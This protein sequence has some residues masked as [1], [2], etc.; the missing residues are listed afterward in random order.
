MIL[1]GIISLFARAYGQV[2]DDY[3]LSVAADASGFAL[4]GG[5]WSWGGQNNIFLVKTD[6]DGIGEWATICGGAGNDEA[7]AITPTSDGGY[8]VAG[9]TFTYGIGGDMIVLKVTGTGSLSWARVIGG[10]YDDEARGIAEL[11]DGGYVVTGRAFIWGNGYDLIFFKLNSDGSYGGWMRYFGGT[12][13]DYGNW[14][15]PTSDG[16]FVITGGTTS[17]GPVGGD[18]TPVLLLNSSGIR[19]WFSVIGGNSS[20]STIGN[21]VIQT[22]DGGFAVAGITSDFGAGGYD[23]IVFKLNSSGSLVWART[24][25]GP[26]NDYAYSIAEMDDGGLVIAGTTESY[27]LGSNEAMVVKMSSDGGFLWARTFGGFEAGADDYDY[28]KAITETP[29]GLVALAGSTSSFGLSSGLYAFLVTMGPDGEYPAC[30]SV[31]DPNI[32]NISPSTTSVSGYNNISLTISSPSVSYSAVEPNQEALCLPVDGTEGQVAP[33]P[34][35]CR[36][37]PGGLIFAAGENIGLSV[38]SADGRLVYSGQLQ[39]GENRIN[40]DRGVYLWTTKPA[41]AGSRARLPYRGNAV[42]R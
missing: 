8:A 31:C 30:V 42:V 26:D 22:S 15:S 7:L 36:A 32:T 29:D 23:F 34:I 12:A 17:Y 9:L 14:V 2:S 20:G 28:G 11:S 19:V 40:L 10:T 38:Y 39:K 5:T 27:G 37:V 35:T 24:I 25:G 16:G 18:N 13:N 21:S 6:P 3:A 1:L 33:G 4:A 41:W